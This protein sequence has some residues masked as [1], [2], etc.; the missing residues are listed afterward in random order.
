[1]TPTRRTV[2]ASA[3]GTAGLALAGCLG[4]DD[5]GETGSEITLDGEDI[6]P[7]PVAG[8]PDADVTVMVFEDFSCGGCRSYKQNVYPEIRDSYIDPE[9]IRYEHHDFPIPV[10]DMWSWGI[11]GAARSVHE[12]AGDEAFWAFTE[13]IYDHQGQYAN[14][15]I[16]TV[17]EEINNDGG[18]GIDDDTVI[19]DVDEGTYRD[20]LETERDRAHEAGVEGTPTVVVDGQLVESSLGAIESA[21]EDAL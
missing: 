5:T 14:E 21:I 1:M 9:S 8:D 10:D 13:L 19:T 17:V 15:A 16:R 18:Y 12:Q 20:D 11:A 2:L 6:L 7:V 3:A 4:D